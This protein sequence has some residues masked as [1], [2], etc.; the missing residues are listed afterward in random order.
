[1]DRLLRVHGFLVRS[2]FASA[3]LQFLIAGVLFALIFPIYHTPD[4]KSHYL[5]GLTNFA[6]IFQSKNEYCGNSTSLETKFPYDLKVSSSS[7]AEGPLETSCKSFHTYGWKLN[8]PSVLLSALVTEDSVKHPDHAYLRFYLARLLNGFFVVWIFYRL[9]QLI[10][11]EGYR[12]GLGIIFLFLISPLFLQ[13]SWSVTADVPVNILGLEL[14]LVMFYLRSL[15]KADLIAFGAIAL[16][17]CSSKPILAPLIPVML[18]ISYGI[19]FKEASLNWGYLKSLIRQ[20]FF[21]VGV[22]TAVI[23][24]AVGFLQI[25][26]EKSRGDNA[27]GAQLQFVLNNPFS[28]W[29]ALQDTFNF[30]FRN[31]IYYFYTS[32]GYFKI[33]PPLYM[34]KI[35]ERLTT[36]VMLLELLFLATWLKK[37]WSLGSSLWNAKRAAYVSIT[38]FLGVVALYI[39]A[40]LPIFVMYL[41]WTPVGSSTV[42]GVQARYFFPVIFCTIALIASW[43]GLISGQTDIR[44]NGMLKVKTNTDSVSFVAT[45]ALFS[46]LAICYWT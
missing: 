15:K 20:K 18:L 26:A 33:P 12:S 44:F 8:Y 17:A 13:Q 2:L 5:A 25:G 46:L 24:V 41:V 45:F 6:E 16:I 36:L 34:S 40:L 31:T 28:A 38:S 35:Y 27:I 1:M 39:S 30:F 4:E 9:W 11:T 32:L 22:V 21:I 19:H 10:R 29:L 42:Q 3:I 23:G 43:I 7:F 37:R 14:A